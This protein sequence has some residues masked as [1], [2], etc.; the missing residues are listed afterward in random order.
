[1][2]MLDSQGSILYRL[3]VSRPVSFS[4]VPLFILEKHKKAK[5]VSI[6]CDKGQP[7]INLVVCKVSRM[8]NGESQNGNS[9]RLFSG[10]TK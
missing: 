4:P 5:K 1:M 9:S 8:I 6:C 7:H 10:A 2:N 3:Q